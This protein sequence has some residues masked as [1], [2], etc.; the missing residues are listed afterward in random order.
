[1]IRIVFFCLGLLLAAPLAQAQ[2]IGCGPGNPC[3][4]T[5]YGLGN[6]SPEGPFTNTR[7]TVRLGPADGSC[8]AETVAR[9]VGQI[10][11]REQDGCVAS[12]TTK[13]EVEI[14][15]VTS[16]SGFY[17]PQK[18]TLDLGPGGLIAFAVA[19]LTDMAGNVGYRQLSGTCGVS[20]DEC[21][22]DAE[23]DA[24][25]AGD[26]CTSTC[27]S[28]PGTSCTAENDAACPSLDC[29]TEIEWDGVG[30]CTDKAT[31]CNTDADC[32]GENVC[33]AGLEWA[34]SDLSCV[35]C[36]S[37]AGIFCN[38]FFQIDE[39][40][41]VTCG[42]T[43]PPENHVNAPDWLFAG[44]RGTAFDLE[45]IS[46]PNQQEGICN[47]N[48]SRPCGVLGDR[49]AGGQNGK[50][51]NPGSCAADPFNPANLALASPCDDVAFGGD[52]ADFCDL[53]EKGTRTFSGLN[54]DGTQNITV[55]PRW[56]S[57]V[58]TPN[59]LCSVA[60]NLGGGADPQPGCQLINIGVAAEA[61]LDC[62]GIVDSDAR[63][64]SARRWRILH[65][66]GALPEL[67]RG[68]RLRLRELRQ[69][70]R[71]VPGT[72]RV[73]PLPGHQ[74]RRHRRPMPVR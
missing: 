30:L 2:H 37:Q 72:G 67:Q 59:Q 40:P 28:D 12:A 33:F 4:T 26:T 7:A 11:I 73:Q 54:P 36:Q 5:S 32:P 61:D 34:D 14:P 52:A 60:N 58:G 41:A 25:N 53:S 43:Q 23:C 42:T 46:V 65:R 55:C 69:Q 66:S 8:G 44:G 50:C 31:K 71:P 24:Q 48:R 3:T 21:A 68:R 56:T 47:I 74:Q 19:N 45:Q 6:D 29:Q 70:R 51:T 15:Q 13:C 62:D 1:M 10:K 64:L 22:L 38:A 57:F 49:Q 27:F 9:S 39:Y 35:C 16:E 17:N 18:L 63:P 20:G